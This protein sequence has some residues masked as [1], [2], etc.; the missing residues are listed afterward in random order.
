[1]FSLFG[2]CL[3]TSFS[4]EKLGKMLFI[5]CGHTTILTGVPQ[6]K[7]QFQFVTKH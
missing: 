4:P 2:Y 5:M 3:L 1:M 6:A 7:P